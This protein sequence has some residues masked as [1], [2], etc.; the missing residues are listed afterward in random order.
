MRGG[1]GRTDSQESQDAESDSPGRG[2]AHRTASQ[3]PGRRHEGRFP[4][5]GVETASTRKAPPRVLRGVCPLEPR[6]VFAVPGRACT[7]TSCT[8]TL[9]VR[10]P[11]M[12]ENATRGHHR[13]P[14]DSPSSAGRSQGGS[15]C[16]GS[17]C[18]T[19]ALRVGGLPSPCHAHCPSLS[20]KGQ[21][22]G[23]PPG[24]Q[25]GATRVLTVTS[26]SGLIP[27]GQG[28]VPGPCQCGVYP[29]PPHGAGPMWC[30]VQ[31]PGHPG[32]VR[33]SS[34]PWEIPR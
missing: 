17:V 5:H 1:R 19:G 12:A 26:S 4:V 11:R 25:A 21:G 6:P 2:Q 29:A 28:S 9:H 23:E 34:A 18:A 24:R 20:G 33:T 13:A 31:L 15:S 27:R 32:Q 3:E 30:L 8:K 7:L 16:R 22:P 10:T 14:Q